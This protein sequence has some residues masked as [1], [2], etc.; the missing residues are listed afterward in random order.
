[1][2]KCPKCGGNLIENNKLGKVYCDDCGFTQTY[3]KV[4]NEEK[5]IEKQEE[6][7]IENDKKIE[8]TENT[9]CPSCGATMHYNPTSQKLHCEFCGSE[10]DIENEVLEKAKEYDLTDQELEK[11]TDWGYEHRVMSCKNC[12]A[13]TNIG[14][15]SISK[16]CPFC[17][18][19]NV[20]KE[21]E[22]ETRIKPETVIPFKVDKNACVNSFKTWLAGKWL[23]PNDLK[24][25]ALSDKLQGV[26]LPY[27][28]FDSDTESHY[29]A[30]RGDYYYTTH[31]DSKGNVHRTR[32][33]RWKRVSG[34]YSKF[35][36]DV[37]IPASKNHRA[38]FLNKI[39]S[40]DLNA[41]VPYKADY[42][43]GFLAERYT[44]DLKE[45][46]IYSQGKIDNMIVQGI[47]NQVGGD[48]FRLEQKE[49]SHSQVMFK[50]FLVPLWISNY[51]YKG[52]NYQYVINGQNGSVE[53]DYPLSP[54]KVGLLVILG[55][56]VLYFFA[57]YSGFID[58][59]F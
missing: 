3:N 49:T 8:K 50:H 56:V 5:I 11:D 57:K 31:R 37:M 47:R 39:A 18:S 2:E 36:D 25:L 30:Q 32:H 35:F 19:P 14:K 28:T 9:I 40:Y 16:F 59:Y 48:E 46:W 43:L 6:P 7:K 15:D 13:E 27:W 52:K 53:G 24:R 12:G 38:D 34:D 41:L 55:I 45:A 4:E 33:T 22:K 44:T 51:S 10:K 54:W 58:E 17:G 42:L 23:A 20:V 21:D 29:V 1:M 26:Y